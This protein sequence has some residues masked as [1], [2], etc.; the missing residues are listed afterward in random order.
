[1]IRCKKAPLIETIT[2]TLF[3]LQMQSSLIIMDIS[4]LRSTLCCLQARSQIT[5]SAALPTYS[6]LQL[7]M[8]SNVRFAVPPAVSMKTA[9]WE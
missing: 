2:V 3:P 9:F 7:D 1:M 4:D 5:L 8:K 6:E